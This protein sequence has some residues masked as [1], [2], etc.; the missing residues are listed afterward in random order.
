MTNRWI[1][2]IALLGK[3]VTIE[4]M[5]IRHVPELQAAARDGQLWKLWYTLVPSPDQTEDYV[6][7]ALKNR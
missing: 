3:H 4:P 6:K 2:P 7:T 1:E 5:D